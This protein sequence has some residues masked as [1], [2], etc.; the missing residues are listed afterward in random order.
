M[1][2]RLLLTG[3]VALAACDGGSTCEEN[4]GAQVL[5]QRVHVTVADES[6]SAELADDEVERDRG[7]K[8]RACDREAIL[9]VPEEP[10]PLAV[11][12]CDLVDPIDVFGLRAGAVVYA[13]TLVPCAPPCGD[14]PQVGADLPVDAVLEVPRGA[15]DVTVGD[16]ATWN[17]P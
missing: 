15:V 16:P 2:H 5:E 13:D 4:V 8:K 9:L 6:V 17:I 1:S 12:G 3:V 14:C 11:W 7:W 10:G